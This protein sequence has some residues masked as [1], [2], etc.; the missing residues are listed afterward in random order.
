MTQDMVA[1]SCY[2]EW[3]EPKVVVPALTAILI[4][5]LASVIVPIFMHMSK[6][7][8]EHKYKTLDIRSKVYTEYFKKYEDAAANVGVD[9]EQ[10]SKVTLKNAFLDLLEAN[11]SP[12]AIIKFNDEVGRFPFQIQDSHRKATEEITSLK[13]LGS[14]ELFQL[15]TEFEKLNQEIMTMSIEW[16]NELNHMLG[17]PDYDA[18][19]AKK[20]KIKGEEIKSLKDKIILQMR[21]ELNL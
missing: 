5:I 1:A 14:N 19:V 7:K 9:Y 11:S 18:P 20:M 17:N 8:R 12:E 15:T 4:G 6:S 10:F 3:L 16:L 2:A 13:I 21:S